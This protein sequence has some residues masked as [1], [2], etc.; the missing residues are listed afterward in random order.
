MTLTSLILVGF[1]LCHHSLTSLLLDQYY[2]IIRIYIL[3]CQFIPTRKNKLFYCMSCLVINEWVYQ[4]VMLIRGV[5]RWLE[6]N[7]DNVLLKVK[8]KLG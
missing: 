1:N 5:R 8:I 4:M 2:T 6:N 3:Q 7:L